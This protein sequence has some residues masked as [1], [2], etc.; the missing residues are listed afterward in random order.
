MEGKAIQFIKENDG[1][2]SMCEEAI[3]ILNETESPFSV[4][5]ICGPYRT[6]KSYL[7]NRFLN[8]QKGFSVGPTVNPE[9]RGIY[10]WSKPVNISQCDGTVIPT[11]LID[12]E[13]IG[14]VQQNRTHDVKIFSLALLLCDYLVYNTIGV[15][16]ERAIDMLSLISELSKL[17][18]SKSETLK[19]DDSE[20]FPSFAW[21]LR[22]FTLDLED[23]QGQP[24]TSNQ[25]LENC[26]NNRF[27][28]CV[29]VIMSLI[30]SIQGWT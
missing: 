9:T 16:D 18:A 7:L 20:F 10:M 12:T 13:G 21:V 17:L 5:A 25:Y 8:Q 30:L 24:I 29:Y 4:I 3:N 23:E 28:S 6:G 14:S 2:F 22:D 19:P 27:V 15:I 11:F 26:L 1:K